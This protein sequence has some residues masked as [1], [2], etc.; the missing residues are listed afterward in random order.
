M[1]TSACS[2][3]KGS[4]FELVSQRPA[5]TLLSFSFV[6]CASCG[7]VVGVLEEFNISEAIYNL[8]S[9]LKKVASKLDIDA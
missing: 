5:N 4:T 7:T 3:C 9:I 8:G 1:A 6:Q 2:Q